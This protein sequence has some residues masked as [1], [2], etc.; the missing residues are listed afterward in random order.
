MES[1]QTPVATKSDTEASHLLN[2]LDAIVRHGKEPDSIG[3]CMPDEPELANE[4]T[5]MVSFVWN[6][7]K[8]DAEVLLIPTGLKPRA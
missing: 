7:G 3:V 6:A 2:L 8:S 4:L 5:C 1:N